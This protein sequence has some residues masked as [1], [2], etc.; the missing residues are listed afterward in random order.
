MK[1]CKNNPSPFENTREKL[2][3]QYYAD[4]F[5]NKRLLYPSIQMN[6]R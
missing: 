2:N 5:M 6:I 4:D 3:K 1:L